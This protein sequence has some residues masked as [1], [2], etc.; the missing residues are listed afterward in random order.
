MHSMEWGGLRAVC[1]RAEYYLAHDKPHDVG[2][3]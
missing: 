2:G 1:K 3:W